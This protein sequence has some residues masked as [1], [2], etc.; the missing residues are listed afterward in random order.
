[1]RKIECRNT[2]IERGYLN[3]YVTLNHSTGENTE[4][5]MR[6]FNDISESQNTIF[7]N[8]IL[9][10]KRDNYFN[11]INLF[12]FIV[13]YH[14]LIFE[15]KSKIAFF[16]SPVFDMRHLVYKFVE[17]NEEVYIDFE[18]IIKKKTD[19]KDIYLSDENMKVYNKDCVVSTLNII[20]KALTG[21]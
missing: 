21:E 17:Y 15:N 10:Y 19:K 14:S 18:D 9:L 16:C 4:N 20:R 2:K 13:D 6:D 12:P 7:S 5:V 1:M 3:H 8:A 11:N